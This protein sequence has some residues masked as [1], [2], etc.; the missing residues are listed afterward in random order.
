VQPYDED[1]E[2]GDIFFSFFQLWSTGGMK[3][4][5]ENL[6]P[7]EKTCPSAILSTINSTWI[8]PGSNSGWEA[9]D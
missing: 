6:C 2:K 4:K 1:E 5:G 7:P 9:G 8:D 3:L